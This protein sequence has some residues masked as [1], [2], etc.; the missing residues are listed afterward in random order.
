MTNSIYLLRFKAEKHVTVLFD[1]VYMRWRHAGTSGQVEKVA[2][3][4]VE[5]AMRNLSESL[6]QTQQTSS[7]EEI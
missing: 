4:G 7:I 5:D 6:P 2:V 3:Q 1:N